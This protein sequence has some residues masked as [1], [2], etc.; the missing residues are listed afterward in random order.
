M[1]LKQLIIHYLGYLDEE[2]DQSVLRHI[3]A[4][5]ECHVNRINKRRS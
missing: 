4:F 5:L 2:R 1:N 3:K